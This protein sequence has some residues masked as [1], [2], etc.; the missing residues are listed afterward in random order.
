MSLV[1]LIDPATLNMGQITPKTFK[2]TG[3][4]SSTFVA[5]LVTLGNA[6][7]LVM[8]RSLA[9]RLKSQLHVTCLLRKATLSEQLSK[10]TNK[11]AFTM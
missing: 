2:E 6:K 8:A 1:F 3:E 5:I 7:Q 11:T 10:A 9:L 4:D